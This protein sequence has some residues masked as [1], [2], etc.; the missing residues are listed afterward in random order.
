MN[1]SPGCIAPA[2]SSTPSWEDGVNSTRSPNV[3]GPGNAEQLKPS[4][5]LP[6][7]NVRSGLFLLRDL[8]PEC[9]AG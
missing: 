7:H 1:I 8:Q 4:E 6:P 9:S 3:P 5:E 2:R